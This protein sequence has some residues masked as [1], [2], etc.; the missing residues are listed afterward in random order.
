MTGKN[1]S[2]CWGGKYAAGK[3]VRGG[4]NNAETTRRRSRCLNFSIKQIS[5]GKRGERRRGRRECAP[6]NNM[7]ETSEDSTGHDLPVSGVIGGGASR[8]RGVTL[9]HLRVMDGL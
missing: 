6:P 1:Q 7:W 9:S 4:A 8:D 2:C 3:K 5:V